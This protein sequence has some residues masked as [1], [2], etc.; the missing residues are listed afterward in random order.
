MRFFLTLLFVGALHMSQTVLADDCVVF[1]HGLGRTSNSLNFM[2]REVNQTLRHL[3]INETYPSKK[4]TIEELATEYIPKWVKLCRGLEKVNFVTHSMG[5]IMVRYYLENVHRPENLG[6]VVMMAP[7]NHGSEI[8]D[9]Y[10]VFTSAILGPANRQLGTSPD[11]LPNRLGPADYSLGIIAG[12]KTAN[13]LSHL[14]FDKPN[15][16]KVTVESSKLEGMK[17]H[18]VMPVT[19]T[20]MMEKREVIDQV[21]SFLYRGRFRP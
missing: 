2:S 20:F 15:D 21:I 3:V 7:P 16:G 17:E 11:S 6:H 14:I 8:V 12:N 4:Q 13:P 18:K 10:G 5:G 9:K 19:H 1:V